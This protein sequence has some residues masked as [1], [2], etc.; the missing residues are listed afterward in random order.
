M[1]MSVCV[2]GKL[3]AVLGC[4]SIFVFHYRSFLLSCGKGALKERN[5]DD[6]KEKSLSEFWH[7][8]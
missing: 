7:V 4:S 6:Y 3:G 5:E 2:A 1:I 8:L